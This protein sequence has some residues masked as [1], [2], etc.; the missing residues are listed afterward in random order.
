M[1][2]GDFRPSPEAMLRRVLRGQALPSINPLVDIGNIVSLRR[3]FPVGCHAV[4]RLEGNLEMGE[5]QGT[6][7][8]LPFDGES[9]E[10]PEPGEPVFLEGT[11]VLTRRFCWRQGRRTL[12]LPDTTAVEFNVDALPPSGPEQVEAACREVEELVVRF[13]GGSLRHEVLQEGH[14]RMVLSVPPEGL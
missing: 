1:K 12:T 4:D 11:W 8:F 5:A 13:C 10:R 14:R 3:L 6:E 7:T 9:V 2:P